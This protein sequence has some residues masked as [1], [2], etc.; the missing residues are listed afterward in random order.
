MGIEI[1]RAE[2]GLVEVSWTVGPEHLQPFGIVHGG[3]FS[4]VVETVCSIGACVGIGPDKSV[5]GMEN[6]TSFLRPVR[7]GVLRAEGRPVHR[8]RTTELWEAKIVDAEGRL[9]AT[10]R[11]RLM[12]IDLP[13]G[14][15]Q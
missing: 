14:K 12:L 6:Q 15:N 2:R 13:A 4:G 8:G 7:E 3:V 9:V 5:V 1:V 11:L 10:G